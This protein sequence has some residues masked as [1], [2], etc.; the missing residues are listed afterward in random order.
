MSSMS[1][2]HQEIYELAEE[3]QQENPNME[4][5]DMATII[6]DELNIPAYRVETVLTCCDSDWDFDD[7]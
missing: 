2:L 7:E 3:L 1:Q 6:A 5:L 4:L